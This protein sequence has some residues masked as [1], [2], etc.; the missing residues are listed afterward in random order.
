MD[1]L[2]CEICG[3]KFKTEKELGRHLEGDGYD[4]E[5]V[6]WPDDPPKGEI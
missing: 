1:D 4:P 6:C 2:I 3:E 5:C